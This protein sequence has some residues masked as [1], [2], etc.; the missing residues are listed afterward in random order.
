M[1]KFDEQT[2]KEQIETVLMAGSETSALTL[3]YTILLL[4]MHPDVQ[5]RLFEELHSVFDSQEEE[6]TYD[7]LQRLTYL[8]RILKEVMR[9]FPSAPL[10]AR[11][12][13]ADI[14]LSNC[15]APKGAFIMMSIF[16]MHRVN[17]S[18]ILSRFYHDFFTIFSRFFTIFSTNLK[19]NVRSGIFERS[20][21]TEI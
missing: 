12:T 17:F 8:D 15:T 5:D 20:N 13:R 10:I 21:F 14:P 7:H 9:L 3:S 19:K 6:T 4:A 18:T 2:I 11:I 16:N 1:G